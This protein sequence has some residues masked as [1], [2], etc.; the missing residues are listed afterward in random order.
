MEN[1]QDDIT[2]NDLIAA[3]E[4]ME[5]EA[6]NQRR[7]TASTSRKPPK[8]KREKNPKR[9]K[10][11]GNIADMIEKDDIREIAALVRQTHVPGDGVARA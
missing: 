7:Q 1:N 9:H 11:N 8:D 4:N 5:M 10:Q 6:I 2:N 3:S